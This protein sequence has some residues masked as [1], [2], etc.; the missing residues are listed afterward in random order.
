MRIR[1]LFL[2][3]L[4]VS[5]LSSCT[6]D[7]DTAIFSDVQEVTTQIAK[8][9]TGGQADEMIELRVGGQADE[10][11]ELRVGGQADE[12][13]ELKFKLIN[14]S[15]NQPARG[16]NLTLSNDTQV[17]GKRTNKGGIAHLGVEM[18]SAYVIQAKRNH[19]NLQF[20]KGEV[21][22]KIIT[23]YVSK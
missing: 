13:I 7:S 11:I 16:V 10:M 3:I 15:D 5:A 2:M 12:M 20:V 4:F 14:I 21:K 17:Y 6:K 19:K 23:L 18:A 9:D 8:T 1:I 22:G